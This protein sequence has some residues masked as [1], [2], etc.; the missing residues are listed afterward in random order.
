MQ[1][2][3]SSWTELVH[4]FLGDDVV[5]IERKIMVILD[6]GNPTPT[7]KPLGYLTKT[8]EFKSNS[9]PI[10]SIKLLDD[11][12]GAL[13]SLP[14]L[15]LLKPG[16]SIEIDW[17][18]S[19]NLQFSDCLQDNNIQSCNLNIGG[20]TIP[21]VVGV[22]GAPNAEKDPKA[23]VVF[24]DKDKNL[25][26]FTSLKD[27]NNVAQF[28]Q[29][30][31]ISQI[32]H[33]EII[34]FANNL[35]SYLDIIGADG[36][37]E[38]MTIYSDIH[39]NDLKNKIVWGLK[40]SPTTFGIESVQFIIQGKPKISFANGVA[41]LSASH[42]ITRNSTDI[43]S[44][45]SPYRPVFAALFRS[46]RNDLGFAKTRV[47][48]YAAGGRKMHIKLTDNGYIDLSKPDLGVQSYKKK[49]DKNAKL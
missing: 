4:N 3:K 34:N 2:S 9:Y 47:F 6:D 42:I 17:I 26:G 25:V 24:V 38:S 14:G 13:T 37:P 43:V 5:D 30:G 36:V 39:N 29:W 8:K 27:G 32:R 35:R 41:T 21:N 31:G 40:C 28:H 46:D 45:T 1:H 48:A 18:H 33:N 11:H 12:W 23:D 49:D 10:A 15:T 7:L 20:I 44:D 22:M 19:F 16:K